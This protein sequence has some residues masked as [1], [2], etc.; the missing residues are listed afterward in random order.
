MLSDNDKANR[1]IDKIADISNKVA[2]ANKRNVVQTAIATIISKNANDYTVR[3]LSSPDYG[4]EDFN[5]I[6]RTVES[7]AVNDPV[8]L[9]YVGDL[10]NAYIAMKLDGSSQTSLETLLN[11]IKCIKISISSFS[12]LPQTKNDSKIKSDMIVFESTLS[13]PAAQT[14]DWTV[15]TSNGS[16]KVTGTISGSTALDLVLG[17]VL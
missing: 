10:T 17:K 11:D 2:V 13:N 14:G 16:L 15:T 8:M 3:L 12:S 5:V 9:H 1:W 7:L 4:S 6:N